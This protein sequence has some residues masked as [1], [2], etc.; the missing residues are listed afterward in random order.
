MFICEFQEI[1]SGR[2]FG[3]TR[4]PSRTA[5]ERHAIV[6]LKKLGEPH[7]R[8]LAAVEVASYGCADTQAGGYGVRIFQAI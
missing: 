1:K 8:V 2:Y 4:H 7:D 5:A 6:E 3:Q